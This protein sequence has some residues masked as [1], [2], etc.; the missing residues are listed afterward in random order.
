MTSLG[1]FWVIDECVWELAKAPLQMR[2]CTRWIYCRKKP[3]ATAWLRCVTAF[4]KQFHSDGCFGWMWKVIASDA[5]HSFP[6]VWQSLLLGSI[7]AFNENFFFA[8]LLMSRN[9]ISRRSWMI[10]SYDAGDYVGWTDTKGH[11]IKM[12]SVSSG[13]HGMKSNIYYHNNELITNS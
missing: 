2:P 11:D 7:F 8:E 9:F 13:F 5:S 6:W 1:W 12:Y 3:T 10:S 4:E